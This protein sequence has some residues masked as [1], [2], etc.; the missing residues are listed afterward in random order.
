MLGMCK[1]PKA[2]LKTLSKK[3]LRANLKALSLVTEKFAILHC[4]L[5]LCCL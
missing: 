1:T 4:F 3:D 5:N 2:R